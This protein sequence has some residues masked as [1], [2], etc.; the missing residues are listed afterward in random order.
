MPHYHFSS[1][2]GERDI[3]AEGV[4]LSGD[5]AARI[6]AI[7]YVGELLQSEPEIL[8]DEGQWRVEVTDDDGHLRFTVIALALAAP[9]AP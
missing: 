3:D 8:C 7:R 1:V 2:D 5:H 6:Y 4:E 9:P